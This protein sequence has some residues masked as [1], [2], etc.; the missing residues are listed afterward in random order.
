MANSKKNT[1]TVVAIDES[2]LMLPSE[3]GEGTK[4]TSI[5]Y[6]AHTKALLSSQT[7]GEQQAHLG[8]MIAHLGNQWDDANSFASGRA[9]KRT[10]VVAPLPKNPSA[11]RYR[12]GLWHDLLEQARDLRRVLSARLLTAEDLADLTDHSVKWQPYFGVFSKYDQAQIASWHKVQIDGQERR[13]CGMFSLT[14][15]SGYGILR[16]SEQGWTLYF[17]QEDK[18]TLT[19]AQ[20]Y[21][22]IAK[23]KLCRRTPYDP[24]VVF[25]GGNRWNGLTPN[26]V[27]FV[28]PAGAGYHEGKKFIPLPK[29]ARISMPWRDFNGLYYA[30]LA[31]RSSKAQADAGLVELAAHTHRCLG[32]K[33]MFAADLVEVEYLH[34]SQWLFKVPTDEWSQY[35]EAGRVLAGYQPKDFTSLSAFRKGWERRRTAQIEARAA[36]EEQAQAAKAVAQAD[37]VAS[38]EEPLPDAM[39]DYEPEDPGF[40]EYDDDLN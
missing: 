9:N 34:H 4:S 35:F 36:R 5:S 29:E 25:P 18:R 3:L 22:L 12:S 27:S 33:A 38:G 39:L 2:D 16:A 26:G 14:H 17:G 6:R 30:T 11:A 23:A 20:A 32:E 19:G 13:L 40:P 10:G 37:M 24:G 8:E 15:L 1:A 21:E 31:E 28:L 7:Q